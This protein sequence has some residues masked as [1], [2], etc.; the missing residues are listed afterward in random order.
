MIERRDQ[1]HLGGS[2][3][4]RRSPDA[5]RQEP[6]LPLSDSDSQCP[7]KLTKRIEVCTELIMV[8]ENGCFGGR[9]QRPFHRT[10]ARASPP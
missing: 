1:S 4:R 7:S 5:D 10:N 8:A 2:S 9:F 3:G 6:H